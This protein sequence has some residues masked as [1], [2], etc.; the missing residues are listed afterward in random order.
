LSSGFLRVQGCNVSFNRGG[1]HR[2]NLPN[3]HLLQASANNNSTISNDPKTILDLSRPYD[4]LP[5]GGMPALIFG[6]KR[7]A[8][9]LEEGEEEN[10]Q[11]ITNGKRIAVLASGGS[12]KKGSEE[13]PEFIRP[14]II[15]PVSS[16]SQIR[17]G[18]PKVR[19]IVS[20]VVD[21][22]GLPSSN[23]PSAT[24]GTSTAGT[25]ASSSSDDYTFEARNLRNAGE[26]TRL[27][28]SRH[29]QVLWMDFV[30][31][32]ALLVTGNSNFWSVACED[33]TV[34]VFTPVG[35]RLSSPLILEAQ[36]CFMEC[37]GWWLMCI[38]SIGMAYVW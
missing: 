4:G 2:S 24:G 23:V 3:A 5:K 1:G 30:P 14:A 26:P 19:N 6:N 11:Q 20:R 7:K 16:V 12:G 29:S 8:P 27:T 15:N 33:G 34:H 36:P 18:V 21:S 9:L 37:R 28:L 35:R 38:T 17:L 13:T 25:Q 22:S 31:K 10:P 32:A